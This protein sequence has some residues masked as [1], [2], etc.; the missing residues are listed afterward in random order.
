MKFKNSGLR[1]AIYCIIGVLL[2]VG[3]YF[4]FPSI[5]TLVKKLIKLFLPFI[6]GYLFSLLINPLADKLQKKMKLPRGLSAILVIILT[7][8]I[9]GGAVVGI[10]WKIVSEIRSLYEHSAEIS[11]AVVN[12]WQNISLKF[13]NFYEAMPDSVQNVVDNLETSLGATVSDIFGK[14]QV[15][16]TAGNFAKGVPGIFIGVIIF[17]L[18]LYF[19]VVDAKTVSAFWRKIFPEKSLEKMADM[20]KEF[21]K[22]IGGYFKAQGIIMSIAFVIIFIGLSILDVNYAL[23][24]ALGIALL[25]AL[26]FFGSGAVLWPWALIGFLNGSVK[27]GVGL[28]IIY[29]AIVFTRQMIEPKIVS[30]NIGLH[31]IITLLSMYIGLKLLSIGGMILGPV[32]VILVKSFYSAGLFDPIIKLFKNIWIL[33]KYEYIK[34]KNTFK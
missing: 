33:L 4:A 25:D 1:L 31:P 22:C 11:N 19:M 21:K 27:I 16:E 6:L 18:S 12:I 15:V 32:I 10:V 17:F 8:G 24:I 26:P 9:I 13:S 5:L 14:V 3:I 30:N 29:L 34:L 23:L 20:R 2:V 28:I 7:V